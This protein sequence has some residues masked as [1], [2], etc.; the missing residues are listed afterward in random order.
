MQNREILYVE[1]EKTNKNIEHYKE[2]IR[3]HAASPEIH[4]AK[5]RMLLK[6]LESGIKH[7]KK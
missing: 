4:V 6:S 1:L 5:I 3:K 7:A 2:Q